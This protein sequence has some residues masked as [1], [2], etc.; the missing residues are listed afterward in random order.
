MSAQSQSWP[1]AGE[2]CS[3]ELPQ[4]PAHHARNCQICHHP[5][6]RSIQF[7]FLRWHKPTEIAQEFG[8][9]DRPNVYRHARAAGLYQRRRCTLVP[10]YERMLEN[11]DFTKVSSHDIMVAAQRLERSVHSEQL[12]ED[13]ALDGLRPGCPP[14]PPPMILRW[15]CPQRRPKQAAK[16]PG[17]SH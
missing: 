15:Q 6:R 2:A 3:A 16:A 10:V 4:L 17:V 9:Y 13:G 14:A 11:F 1:A 5:N 8:L 7:Q 12:T